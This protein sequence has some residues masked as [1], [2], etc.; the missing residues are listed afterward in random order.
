MLSEEFQRWLRSLRRHFHRFPELRYEEKRTA[1]KIQE[2]LK[3][4]QIPFQSGIAGTGMI[5]FIEAGAPGPVV[6]MRAD[7]DA[8]PLLEA[9]EVPYKSRHEGIMHACGHDGHM[10]IAL[11]AARWL[12]E[13]RWREWGKGKVLFFFQPAEEGGAGAKAMIDA[14][15]LEGE[16]IEVIFAGHLHPELPV[17]SIGISS[18]VSNAACDTFLIRIEGTGGHGAHPD[19]CC[20]P[21]VAGCHLVAMVQTVVSRNIAPQDSA[22]LSVGRFQA[23]TA[24]NIIP[25]EVVMEGTLRTLSKEVRDVAMERLSRLLEGLGTSF[26]VQGELQV[27]PGYP[28][29]V[30]DP[31]VVAYVRE[32]AEAFPGGMMVR[33]EPASMGAEDFAYFLQ[34]IPG[35]LIRLGCHDPHRGYSCGLHSPFFDFDET[36]LDLGVS[37]FVDLLTHYGFDG[38]EAMANRPHPK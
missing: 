1:S 3:D 31:G 9:N 36:V 4:L 25:R 6:A 37:F 18:K 11:G 2:T 15:A 30:N 29:V 32:R 22:V 38:S 7:M 17:G 8:L 24:S 23:G 33:I 5:A 16:N 14:G 10:A 35:A 28:P 20:D 12:K 21:I 26:G 19:L 13:N 27:F 34:K